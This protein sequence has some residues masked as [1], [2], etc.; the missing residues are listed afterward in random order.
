MTSQVTYTL[1]TNN[2][3]LDGYDRKIL[4]ALLLAKTEMGFL[5]LLKKLNE[6]CKFNRQTLTT[7]LKSLEERRYITKRKEE[8]KSPWQH[9]YYALNYEAL[10][11][12]I[13]TLEPDYKKH[14]FYEVFHEFNKNIQDLDFER[15]S[16]AILRFIYFADLMLTKLTIERLRDEKENKDNR[17]NKRARDFF[18]IFLDSM[19]FELTRL[20]HNM[21]DEAFKL[22]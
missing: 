14:P 10:N 19:F 2:E 13:T 8:S 15:L 1:S 17:D 5:K 18:S 6:Q 22:F 16:W 21:K 12:Y 7:H 11:K 9:S 20:S 3:E 4:M